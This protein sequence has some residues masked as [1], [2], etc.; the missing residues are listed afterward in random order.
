MVLKACHI[1][2]G[3]SDSII[4][5]EDTPFDFRRPDLES[6]HLMRLDN[7]FELREARKMLTEQFDELARKNPF[8]YCWDF[9]DSTL[10]CRGYHILRDTVFART[11]SALY[12]VVLSSLCILYRRI[13]AFVT[14]LLNSACP[15]WVCEDT[16]FMAHVFCSPVSSAFSKW[17][18][19][20]CQHLDPRVK[21]KFEASIQAG[22]EVFLD[23]RDCRWPCD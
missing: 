12:S 6:N 18:M 5:T 11:T 13:R 15:K 4:A 20:Q 9:F 22:L 16:G 19:M 3:I 21:S 8:W 7:K 2:H 10:Y 14:R 23:P 1:F 17:R